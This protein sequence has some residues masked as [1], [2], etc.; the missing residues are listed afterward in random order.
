MAK[1]SRFRER[2]HKTIAVDMN[3]TAE[4]AKAANP[5]PLPE[6]RKHNEVIS[7]TPPVKDVMVKPTRSLRKMVRVT[8]IS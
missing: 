4:A 3:M 5:N 1:S 6:S 8:I 7:V 2:L